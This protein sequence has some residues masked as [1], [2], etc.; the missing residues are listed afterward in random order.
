VYNVVSSLR[1]K[2][3][4]SRLTVVPL[5]IL[6]GEAFGW[7]PLSLP[8]AIL[9]ALRALQFLPPPLP[10]PE[11]PGLGRRLLADLVSASVARIARIAQGP[12]E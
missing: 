12:L 8:I 3:S 2:V 4:H 6:G 9:Q 5:P 10:P 1:G 11:K 7:G